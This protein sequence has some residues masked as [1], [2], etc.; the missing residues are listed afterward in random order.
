MGH[1]G[2]RTYI[3]PLLTFFCAYA[4][5]V[6]IWEGEKVV[7]VASVP[8]NLYEVSNALWGAGVSPFVSLVGQV[9]CPFTFYY[10]SRAEGGC[11][12]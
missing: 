12:A 7:T 9:V 6:A 5:F 3:G 11:A 8:H 1:A 4:M 2:L 10:F